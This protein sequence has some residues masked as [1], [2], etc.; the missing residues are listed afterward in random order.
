MATALQIITK[1]LRLRQALPAG[2]SPSAEDAA[3]A[4][5]ELNSL[6]AEWYEADIKLPQY[7]LSGLTANTTFDDAD[8]YAV[9]GQLAKRLTDYGMEMSAEAVVMADEAMGRL[10]LRYFQPGCV[11]F[12]ELPLPTFGRWGYSVDNGDL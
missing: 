10:R 7:S 8:R 1:A 11:N 2:Q 3:D 5:Y 6:L 9:E 4:L 12:N